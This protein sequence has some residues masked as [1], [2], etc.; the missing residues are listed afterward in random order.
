[1]TVEERF[2]KKVIK[3]P[4]CWIWIGGKDSG[5]YGKFNLAGRTTSTHRWSFFHFGG[6]CP[7]TMELDHLCKNRA[8]VNPAHLE[9]VTPTENKRRSTSAAVTSARLKKITHCKR[10]H[11]YESAYIDQFGWRSCRK[12]GAMRALQYYYQRKERALN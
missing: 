3:T 10:G 4:T 2:F 12:C 1:M 7:K 11:S 8:C 9:A 6:V 5:G